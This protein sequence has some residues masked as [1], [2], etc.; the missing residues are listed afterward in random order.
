[1]IHERHQAVSESAEMY[2][3]ECYLLTRDDT[4][5]KTGELADRLEVSAP[6]VTEMLTK[7]DRDGL[8]EYQKHRGAVLTD[9]GE[10][11][12][13]ALLRKHCL[14]ERFLDQQLGLEAGVHDEACRLEHAMSDEVARLLEEQVAIDPDCPSCYDAELHHCRKL[15]RSADYAD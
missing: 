8:L 7:L 9:T 13:K 15:S 2:L 12:A 3:K 10:A 4:A 1:M 5:A 11:Q 14:I 6:A